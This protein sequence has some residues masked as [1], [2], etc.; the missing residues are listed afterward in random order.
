MTRGNIPEAD[1]CAKLCLHQLSRHFDEEFGGFEIAP[2]FPQPSNLLFLFH[3]YS[4][5]KNSAPGQSALRM[6]LKT[7]KQMNKGGIHDHI[8]QVRAF[9][10]VERKVRK[11]FHNTK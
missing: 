10:V 6:A 9:V 5:E 2:K 4:R 3:F 8:G 7:L 11:Y 1:E